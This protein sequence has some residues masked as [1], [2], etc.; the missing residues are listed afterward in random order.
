MHQVFLL[1]IA[2][3][4]VAGLRSVTAPALV[5]W[6]AYLGWINL[7]GSPLSFMGSTIA[8]AVFSLAAIGELIADKLPKTPAR[9]SAVP[10]I[11]RLFMGGLC[12]ACLYA[13]SAAVPI[14]GA[15][16]GALGALIGAFAGYYVRR[17]LVSALKVRDLIIAIPEDIIAIVLAYVVVRSTLS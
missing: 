13:A 15:I 14:T 3:G 7:H 9:I 8:V 4:F 1:A 5:S 16:L 6:G 17:G 11:G 12:G 10:L 2:I